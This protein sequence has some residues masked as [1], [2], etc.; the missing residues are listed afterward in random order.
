MSGG[1]ARRT[2]EELD[3]LLE[4]VGVDLTD[5][6]EWDDD[7]TSGFGTGPG[8]DLGVGERHPDVEP[9]GEEFRTY[10]DRATPLEPPLADRWDPPPATLPDRPRDEAS[11]PGSQHLDD[12]AA[13]DQLADAA[14]DLPPL[15]APPGMRRDG[16]GVWRYD[17]GGDPVPGARDVTLARTYR[18]GRRRSALTGELVVPVPEPLVRAADELAWCGRYR[19]GEGRFAGRVVPVREVP[20]GEW[21]LRAQVP[22]AVEA[23]ELRPEALLTIDDVAVTAGVT[24]QTISTYLARRQMPE[25]QARVANSPLWSLPVVLRWLTTRPGSGTRPARR[26]TRR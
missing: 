9:D 25:P 15:V 20:V 14:A 2:L 13:K 3:R 19:C 24:R 1:G 4:E 18:F 17:P 11:S 12:L 21:A 22:Y 8:D 23:P 10:R 16:R 5:D 6:P 26:R 7:P